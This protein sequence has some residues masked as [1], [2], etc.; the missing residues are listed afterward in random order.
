M[1]PTSPPPPTPLAKPTPRARGRAT[2]QRLLDAAEAVLARNGVEGATVPAIAARAGVSVGNV[3]KRFPDKDA[4]LR[5][6]YERF[7]ARALEQNRDA[8]DAA[9]WEGVATADLL[10]RII[11]GL[12]AG[13]R[14]HRGLIRALLLYAETHPDAGFRR[15]AESLR[16]ETLALMGALLAGRR[17]DL[18][19]PHPERAIRI[20]VGIVAL[21]LQSL[22]LSDR[23]APSEL[24]TLDAGVAAELAAMVASYLGVKQRAP[25]RSRKRSAPA[26]VG[27]KAPLR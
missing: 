21:A 3:Y 12:V 10:C 11:T 6:V 15:R 1:P 4:L 18:A 19:H 17:A 27:G 23:T 13:Y 25:A 20:A 5:A 7:F 16:H 9:R 24:A 8:L 26:R 14:E 2:L 22:V